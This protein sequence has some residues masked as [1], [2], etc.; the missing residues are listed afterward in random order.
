MLLA[1]GMDSHM[2]S[3]VGRCTKT[4]SDTWGL[5]LSH[6]PPCSPISL[7]GLWPTVGTE[8]AYRDS[9]VPV[10]KRPTERYPLDEKPNCTKEG[11]DVSP[12][13]H[14]GSTHGV[15]QKTGQVCGQHVET[16][17]RRTICIPLVQEPGFTVHCRS[18]TPFLLMYATVE[19]LSDS[20]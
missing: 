6:P 3:A 18:A 12:T 7:P 16:S 11:D 1:R 15:H 14:P 8:K 10:E 17:A 2:P 19:V 5:R 9:S 20:I 13:S 4:S